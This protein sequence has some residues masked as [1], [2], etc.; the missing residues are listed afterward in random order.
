VPGLFPTPGPPRPPAPE[1]LGEIAAY[2]REY[3]GLFG[4]DCKAILD[5][6]FTVVTP[7]SANPYQQMYVAN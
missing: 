3:C 6:P 7:D 1:D 4:L 2:L 5:A